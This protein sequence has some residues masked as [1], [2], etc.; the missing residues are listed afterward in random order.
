MVMSSLVGGADERLYLG[1]CVAQ[2][3]RFEMPAPR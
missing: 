1:E 3:A 2:L